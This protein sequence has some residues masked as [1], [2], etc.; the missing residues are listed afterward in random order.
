MPTARGWTGITAAGCSSTATACA[1]C[2]P[3]MLQAALDAGMTLER[4]LAGTVIG[5]SVDQEYFDSLAKIRA[6]RLIWRSL[7][8]ALGCETLA[9]IE[10][11]SSRRMLD[12]S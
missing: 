5:L 2:A 9:V 7:T 1:G 8:R 3:T 12:A 4:A 6:M 10:A 11:R